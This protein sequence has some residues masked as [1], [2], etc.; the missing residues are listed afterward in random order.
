MIIGAI[1]C[2]ICAFLPSETSDKCELLSNIDIEQIDDYTTIYCEE[3]EILNRYAFETVYEYTDS[4]GTY[5]DT[6]YYVYDASEPMDKNE[7]FAEYY[8]VKI[9]DKTGNE[10]IA[11][12]I[13]S[14][15]KDMASTLTKTPLKIS[16]CVWASPISNPKLSNSD[17]KQLYQLR[18]TALNEYSKNSKIER[19]PI[20]L[21]YQAES[22]EQYQDSIKKDAVGSKIIM[23]IFSVILALSGIGIGR[24]IRKKTKKNETCQ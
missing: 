13:V 4:E 16:A 2:L 8:I 22:I 1:E 21:T 14:A 17:D 7:L 3:L 9:S 5:I 12:L 19:A 6:T 11:S 18:E 23:I 15:D 10:Y 20:T 24:F